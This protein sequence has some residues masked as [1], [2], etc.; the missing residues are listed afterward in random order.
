MQWV[1]KYLNDYFHANKAFLPWSIIFFFFLNT[2]TEGILILYLEVLINNG[3]FKAIILNPISFSDSEFFFCNY[4]QIKIDSCCRNWKYKKVFVDAI[5]NYNNKTNKTNSWPEKVVCRKVIGIMRHT[6]FLVS[7]GWGLLPQ[8][9]LSKGCLHC[10]P[11]EAGTQMISAMPTGRRQGLAC[12]CL[13]NRGCYSNMELILKP[14]LCWVFH[15][16]D[17]CSQGKAVQNLP[18][19]QRTH[20][21]F[22]VMFIGA[23]KHIVSKRGYV[24]ITHSDML[25]EIWSHI[26]QLTA[27]RVWSSLVFIIL[28]E[29]CSHPHNKF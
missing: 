25:I 24:K 26:T 16:R 6:Y 21:D 18:W 11:P 14:P 12:Y 23:K 2:A 1:G 20:L 9:W 5:R 4:E 19:K 27:F 15:A 7:C 8:L 22:R 29:F 10:S 3:A 17:Q 13:Y 28:I